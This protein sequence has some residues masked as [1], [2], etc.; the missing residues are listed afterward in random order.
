MDAIR[1]KVKKDE[2]KN[3]LTLHKKD[4]STIYIASHIS[5]KKNMLNESESI[6]FL[7]EVNSVAIKILRIAK[8]RCCK[9]IK[10]HLWNDSD[11]STEHFRDSTGKVLSFEYTRAENGTISFKNAAEVFNH[12]DWHDNYGGDAWRDIA[13]TCEKT[14]EMMP[15]TL[16]NVDKIIN[17]LDH[18]MDIEHN[19]GSMFS[20]SSSFDLLNFLEEKS[21]NDFNI[22]SIKR[23][24]PSLYALYSRHNE[25]RI[26]GQ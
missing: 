24:N 22:R 2:E 15:V 19:C 25:E 4:V 7:D 12:V 20:Q 14:E 3:G 26:G 18:I 5:P 10:R 1:S 6:R 17:E 8:I 13:E 9:E 11:W 23:Y 21:C 16:K